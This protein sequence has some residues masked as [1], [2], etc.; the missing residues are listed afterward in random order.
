M[1]SQSMTRAAIQGLPKEGIKTSHLA[2]R[3]TESQRGDVAVQ[4][5]ETRTQEPSTSPLFRP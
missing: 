4:A 5:L 2:D 1:M 3:D